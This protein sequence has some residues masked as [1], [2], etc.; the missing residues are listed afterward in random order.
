MSHFFAEFDVCTSTA[1]LIRKDTRVYYHAQAFD[2]NLQ[3][4][5]RCVGVV[6]MCNPGSAARPT[7]PVPWGGIPPDQT[8]RAVLDLYKKA[9]AAKGGEPPAPEH[10]LLILNCYYAVNQDYEA[11]YLEWVESGCQYH[12]K[13]PKT[14]AFVLAAWGQGKPQGPV[15]RAIQRIKARKKKSGSKLRVVYVDAQ[16]GR[17]PRIQH[18]L[19]DMNYPAHPLSPVFKSNAALAADLAKML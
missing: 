5:G 4:T 11:A 9:V 1:C 6:W 15:H 13:I 18:R 14:A 2:S 19:A 17:P 16:P 3:Q 12:E 10:Y 7:Q 8:L